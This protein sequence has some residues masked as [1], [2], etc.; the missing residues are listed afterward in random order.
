M[1]LVRTIGVA[2]S[3]VALVSAVALPAIAV[4][5]NETICHYN[6]GTKTYTLVN[7]KG[8]LAGS[9]HAKHTQDKAPVDGSCAT[10][11]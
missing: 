3:T 6:T 4:S 10:Q 1:R 5:P 9:G 2:L 11:G 7:V 8:G